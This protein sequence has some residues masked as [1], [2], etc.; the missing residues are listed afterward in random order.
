MRIRSLAGAGISLISIAALASAACAQPASIAGPGSGSIRGQVYDG[1]TGIAVRGATVRLVRPDGSP[2]SGDTQTSDVN[3]AFAFTDLPPGSYALRFERAGYRDSDVAGVAVRA[4]QESRADYPLPPLPRESDSDSSDVEIMVVEASAVEDIMAGLD[5][6]MESDQLL[7]I[8]GAEEFSKFAASDVAD[9]LKRVSG[10]NVVQGQFAI[11]RGLEDRYSS[12]LYNGAPVPSPDPDSQ[13][14]QLDLFASDIV[15]QVVVAKTFASDLPS[16]SSGGAINIV[17]HDYPS[18]LE[19]KFSL[20]GG[21]EE[22][23]IDRFIELQKGSSVG[24]ETDGIDATETD[25]GGSFGGRFDLLERQIRFKGVFNHEVDYRTG[26]GFQEGNEPRFPIANPPTRRRSGDLAL[27]L[28]GLSTGHFDSTE[29]ERAEQITA[30]GGLGFDLDVGGAHALDF[31]TFYTRKQEETVQLRENGFIPGVDYRALAQTFLG[32]QDISF[33]DFICCAAESAWIA[34][35]LRES[36]IDSA[37]RGALWYTDFSSSA[38]FDTDR[39][40]LLFQLNGDHRITA[41]PGLH[42]SW[43]ANHATTTQTESSL[44]GRFFFEPLDVFRLPAVL[45][46]NVSV[47]DLQ[48][49]NYAV[50]GSGIF[51]G[52]ADVSEDQWFARADGDYRDKLASWL[53][54]EVGSGGW[55]ERATRDVSA[56]FLEVASEAS[57]STQFA[58]QAPALTELGRTMFDGLLRSGQTGQIDG[59]RLS[60]SDAIREIHAWSVDGKATLFE[61]LDLLAG[62]RLERI[63][64]TS[65]NDPFVAG[66]IAFDGSPAIFPSKYLFFDRLD[67]AARGEPTSRTR[68]TFNDQII[69]IELPVDPATGLVDLATRE[70]IEALVNGRIDE[71]FILPTAGFVYTP[72]DGLNLRGAYS[73]TVARP[74]FRELGYYV[75]VEPA[76]D[77]QIVGNPQLQLSEVESFDGRVEY[78]WG[79]FGD[80]FAVSAFYKRIDDPIES[81][82]LRRPD[83]FEGSSDALFRTFFNNQNRATLWGIEVEGRKNLE[84]LGFG[85]FDILEFFSIGANVTYIDAEVGRSEAEIERAQ[86]LFQV[87]APATAEFGGLAK[88]RRLFGQPEWIANADL[89]FDQEDWGTKATLSIFAISSVLDAAGSA[90]LGTDFRLRAFTLDRY[91]DSFHQLDLTLSQTWYVELL[92]GD[93]TAKLS[94][95]NLTDSTRRLIYDPE[96]TTKR[97][98]ERSFKLGRDYSFSLSYQF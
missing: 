93:V 15:S 12:T 27:G 43:A 62:V 53:E 51:L 33:S 35:G 30:Y 11:I 9:A 37:A 39:D 95:K 64:I 91:I 80:L 79:D 47:V 65:N 74:S 82:V 57:G 52:A 23:A 73:Q 84:F 36:T 16:N 24:R 89:S 14:V 83:N 88:K 61:V 59:L 71:S 54:I 10:V 98:T 41:I 46:P 96:Q 21:F 90:S 56:S 4:G 20:G 29:S 45:P 18:E 28:L 42:A 92:R 19:F 34:K 72:I 87:F 38:S 31:S 70:E 44:G 63:Q 49:G 26:L 50:N 75:T 94:I 67:N 76:S 17:T 5:L 2:G 40:L 13:S 69:G 81:I 3:G 6:R 22:N 48:P 66:A 85:R 78:T 7:N 58:F 55:Y 86:P 68:T 32:G 25:F 1:K 97:I 60:S 77:D 8:M